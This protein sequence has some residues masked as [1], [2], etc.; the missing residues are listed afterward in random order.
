MR[1]KGVSKAI[2]PLPFSFVDVNRDRWCTLAK[3]APMSNCGKREVE[4]VAL[5]IPSHP[6]NDSNPK[7]SSFVQASRHHTPKSPSGSPRGAKRDR[8]ALV[9]QVVQVPRD[10]LSQPQ[11][12]TFP[13]AQS[14][15]GLSSSTS[16]RGTPNK[17]VAVSHENH[18][19][20]GD[21]QCDWMASHGWPN[22]S[23]EAKVP[24]ARD[25]IPDWLFS[26]CKLQICSA[27]YSSSALPER[28][29]LGQATGMR[30]QSLASRPAA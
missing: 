3:S 21:I 16:S 2:H 26:N 23:Y 30:H 17:V 13:G 9:S 20:Y 12:P 18:E 15:L 27:A 7:R 22:S 10:P 11:T 29:Y 28:A 5:Y 4:K 24:K 14:P 8:L 6:Y 25:I 19:S 1:V